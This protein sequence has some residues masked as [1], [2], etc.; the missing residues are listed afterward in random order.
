MQPGGMTVSGDGF[1][2][3]GTRQ[4]GTNNFVSYGGTFD[5]AAG[6]M[7]HYAIGGAA[8]AQ[9]T[10]ATAPVGGVSTIA[11]VLIGVGLLAIGAAFG[12]FMRE[13]TGGSK[14]ETPNTLDASGLIKQ[15][16]ELDVRYHEGKVA[17][18]SYQQQRNALKERLKA[19]MQRS[20]GSL[21]AK[22]W[23]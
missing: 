11:Y 9:T 16:A 22:H 8:A 3:L 13:R 23:G 1:S 10:T 14:T 5:L 21:T 17:E 19:Q 7:L 15:I 18:A 20:S 6:E 12:F 2:E 4:L